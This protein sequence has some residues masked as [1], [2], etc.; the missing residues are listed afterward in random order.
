MAEFAYFEGGLGNWTKV[1]LWTFQEF[2]VFGFHMEAGTNA[3][4]YLRGIDQTAE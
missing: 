2:M 4:S 1:L 3:I